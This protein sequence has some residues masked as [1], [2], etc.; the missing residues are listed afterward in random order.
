MTEKHGY[1]TDPD[2]VT[3]ERGLSQDKP[4]ATITCKACGA[5]LASR[6]PFCPSCGATLGMADPSHPGI[7]DENFEMAE[8]AMPFQAR[9]RVAH[10]PKIYVPGTPRLHRLRQ[11]RGV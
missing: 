8:D 5:T 9:P 2:K 11:R 10:V 1:L 4:E 7:G 3:L 6:P